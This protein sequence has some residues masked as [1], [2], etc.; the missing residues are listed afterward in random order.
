L[1]ET[2]KGK[3]SL[4]GE[5]LLTKGHTIKGS[6]KLHNLPWGREK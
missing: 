5:D 6:G 4:G 3:V 1:R 2:T